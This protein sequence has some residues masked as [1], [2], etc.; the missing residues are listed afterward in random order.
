VRHFL[1]PAN[2][3]IKG[4]FVSAALLWWHALQA[5]MQFYRFLLLSIF[6]V[7]VP[8]LRAE[9]GLIITLG[10]VRDLVRTQN[11]D[12]AA[13]RLRINEALGRMHQSGRLSNPEIETE[14]G[15]DPRYRER[16]FEIG[17]SQRFP[18][19]NRLR[20]EK[21]VTATLYKASEAEVREVERRLV[22]D[23][24]AAVV[25]VLAI[26]QRRQLLKDQSAIASEFSTFL[27]DAATRGE[28]SQLDAGMAK[29]EATS[30]AVEMRQLDASEAAAEGALKPL[31]G[32]PPGAPVHVGGTLGNAVIP[33]GNVDPS[34][35]PDFQA[36][37]LDA[38]AAGQS[39][40]VE[41]S[42]RYE[43]VKAGLFAA[44][45]RTEDAPEGYDKEGIIGL[46]FT[47][48]LPLWNK[49]EGA[50]EESEAKKERKQL[51]AVALAKSIRLEA[52][53]A[54]SE[55]TEWAKLA[56]ELNGTLLPLAEEQ[57]KAAEDAFRKG[58]GEIQPFA[59]VKSA[60]NSWRQDSTHCANSTLPAFATKRRLANPEPFHP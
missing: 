35:R 52:E 23:A 15:H 2:H 16:R 33:G 29:L 13:A 19:T 7:S 32:L 27:S 8:S 12:L 56:D 44:A 58:Q 21:E 45:Q 46:R 51:E 25:N 37:K 11:P 50:I 41:Q 30:L 6:A 22:G 34:K 57:S 53:A 3:P 28:G 59:L 43:D 38:K 17:F 10:T 60:S 39:V 14:I 42:K 9:E 24:K 49:N 18:V 5:Q 54:K 20:L 40:S 26:R 36:A 55:M 31:L 48:P 1:P 4:L 47:F